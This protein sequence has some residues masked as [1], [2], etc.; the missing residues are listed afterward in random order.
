MRGYVLVDHRPAIV[1][2]GDRCGGFRLDPCW[3]PIR[4]DPP[5]VEWMKP[6]G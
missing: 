3:D 4:I 1:H 6:K 5:F 2:A